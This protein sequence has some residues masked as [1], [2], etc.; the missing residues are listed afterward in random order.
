V[1]L[2][3][4]HGLADERV[5]LSG[6]AGGSFCGDVTTPLIGV[7]RTIECKSRKDAFRELYGW[8]QN[9]DILVLKSDRQNALVVLRL[10]LA[11]EIAAAAE[12]RKP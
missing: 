3:Q 1:R 9:R 10:G 11:V 6:S 7:D 5:P 2:L 12:R 8:L 4:D